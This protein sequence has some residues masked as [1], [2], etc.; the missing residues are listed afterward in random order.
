MNFEFFN[1]NFSKLSGDYSRIKTRPCTSHPIILLA[2]E[3]LTLSL[4]ILAT[5]SRHLVRR[6]G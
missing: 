2:N 6:V 3:V 1:F 4:N 5:M